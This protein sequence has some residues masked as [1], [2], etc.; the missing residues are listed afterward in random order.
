[1][2]V[3]HTHTDFEKLLELLKTAEKELQVK[4]FIVMESTGHYH[5]LLFYFLRNSGYD[6]S[7]VNPIQTD[8][9]KNI[10]IRKVK[11]DKVDAKKVALLARLG[12]IQPTNIPD[13]DILGLRSLVR[14][15]YN[16]VDER[17]AYKNRMTSILDQIMLNYKDIFNNIFSE[18]SLSVLEKYPTPQAIIDAGK[19]ELIKLMSGCSNKNLKWTMD[20]AN[21]LLEKAEAFKAISISTIANITMLRNYISL[22]RAM[23]KSI[24]FIMEGIE[25]HIKKSDSISLEVELLSTIPGINII[26]AATIV[27][28]IGDFSLFK[29]PKKLVAFFGLDSS[30]CQSGQ[31]E[32]SENHISKRGSRL[33]RRVLYMVAL[34]SIREKRNGEKTNQVLYEFY[35]GKCV[36]KP[37]KVALIAV[38]HKLV[39][40]IFA[41]LRDRKPFVLR[42]PE[43]HAKTLMNLRPQGVKKPA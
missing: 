2:K 14:Q 28:E 22:I 34:A 38:M 33:L 29:N 17:T 26:T 8:S 13:E 7:V 3:Y 41:V 20:K 15:Y 12:E 1:M 32:G 36:N 11:S 5:K 9:I 39:F 23:D 42:K 31:F 24:E 4:P 35:E 40:V 21:L 30:V 37:K 19:D 10:G 16:L 27:A 25:A 43:E 18:T 6:A